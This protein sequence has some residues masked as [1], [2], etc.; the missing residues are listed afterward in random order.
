MR[1]QS[2]PSR[3]QFVRV[4]ECG[5]GQPTL[6]ATKTWPPYGC[7]KGVP[8]RFLHNHH[9]RGQRNGRWRNG[10]YHSQG[11]IM[12]YRPDH[13]ASGKRGYVM[14]HRLVMEATLGRLLTDKE[15]VHHKD[16]NRANNTPSNLE[17]LLRSEHPSRHAGQRWS[18][19]H[20]RCLDCGTTERK[21][22]AHGRC[23]RCFSRWRRPPR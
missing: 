15:V 13:P 16:G 9:A 19:Q 1:P 12:R 5:C 21:H 17:V 11:Y 3:Q 7:V 6:V 14:E 8:L 4:C 23:T 2:T 10:T 18:R 22:E 20:D